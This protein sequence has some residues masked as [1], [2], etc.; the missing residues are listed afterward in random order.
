M[1]N[2]YFLFPFLKLTITA[3][4]TADRYD[5]QDYCSQYKNDLVKNLFEEDI[6]YPSDDDDAVKYSAH[7]KGNEIPES[8][9]ADEANVDM[10][11]LVRSP[12]K[13]QRLI[14]VPRTSDLKVLLDD[15]VAYQLRQRQ[16]LHNVQQDDLME[17]LPW[18]KNRLTI[19]PQLSE[20]V[21]EQ[22]DQN[23]NSHTTYRTVLEKEFSKNDAV[24]LLLK[25]HPGQALVQLQ[26]GPTSGGFMLEQ[27]DYVDIGIGPEQEAIHIRLREPQVL[28]R[29]DDTDIMHLHE[30]QVLSRKGGTDDV[31]RRY[32][33]VSEDGMLL[34]VS[35]T[36]LKIG[37]PV[38]M[39]SWLYKAD[40]DGDTELLDSHFS[41]DLDYRC[42][43]IVNIDGS[44]SPY[45]ARD[46]VIG[47][48]RFPSV[49]LVERYSSHRFIF[50]YADTLWNAPAPVNG[51][52]LVLRSHPGLA[53]V[54]YPIY[55]GVYGMANMMDVVVGPAN[56]STF[57]TLHLH[58]LDYRRHHHYTLQDTKYGLGLVPL[59]LK[60][61]AGVPLRFMK[62]NLTESVLGTFA[63]STLLYATNNATW[64]VNLDGSISPL[65]APHLVIGCAY[66]S[67]YVDKQHVTEQRLMS[68]KYHEQQNIIEDNTQWRKVVSVSFAADEYRLV[69][70]IVWFLIAE[71]YIRHLF[72]VFVFVALVFIKMV[73][74]PLWMTIVVRLCFGLTA[75][76]CY[77]GFQVG[78][79]V[80]KAIFKHSKKQN[81]PDVMPVR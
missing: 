66:I 56:N 23:N 38:T 22:Q 5:N 37:A 9:V 70:T 65:S 60:L 29:K 24:P 41:M 59:N 68:W 36:T 11:S 69:H 25:S 14:L 58:P 18:E 6:C 74:L 79:L 17:V 30:Q 64:V 35:S 57:L 50:K 81:V 46:L 75:S 7:N 49:T 16:Q 33:L 76:L 77:L 13:G 3:T 53:I 51:T 21:R 61:E 45:E 8:I 1:R 55:R 32:V 31:T 71:D 63:L 39:T 2:L 44:I 20:L 52:P 67:E 72:F 48:S 42:P 47:I 78:L 80:T 40:D 26:S 4:T 28:S 34:V 73:P 54:S 19:L 10:S 62:Y 27:N 43:F 12:S 15:N